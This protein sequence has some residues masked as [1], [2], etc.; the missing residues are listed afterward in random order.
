L[1]FNTQV[2]LSINGT[3]SAP[4]QQGRGLRQGDPLSPLLFNMMIDPLIRQIA[5]TTTIRGY[6]PWAK[7]Y[8]DLPH[9]MDPDTSIKIMAYADDM[10]VLLQDPK[11]WTALQNIYEIY[12]KASNA[13]LNVNKTEFISMSGHAWPQWKKMQ[14]SIDAGW[15]DRHAS[16]AARYLGYPI[17]SST[18]QLQS[19]W[20]G[21][22]AK[23]ELHC[24]VLSS[25]RLTI[26]GT[27]L[28]CNSIIFAKV[29]HVLRVTPIPKAWLT[30]LDQIARSFVLPFNPAPAWRTAKLPKNMG[31]L[32]IIDVGDQRAALQMNAIRRTLIGT[33][34]DILA[35]MN[36]GMLYVCHGS[37]DLWSNPVWTRKRKRK[38]HEGWAD[39][40]EL[41][42]SPL[43][44]THGWGFTKREGISLYPPVGKKVNIAKITPK[45]A[46][47]HMMDEIAGPMQRPRPPARIPGHIKTAKNAWKTI[48]SGPSHGRS[49]TI[50]WRWLHEKIPTRVRGLHRQKHYTD[51]TCLL[52]GI[53]AE[54]D[55]HF[56]VTCPKKWPIWQNHLP[57]IQ[58]SKILS[59]LWSPETIPPEQY[60]TICKAINSVWSAHWSQIFAPP[61]PTITRN[62]LTAPDLSDDTDY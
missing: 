41:L 45:I 26:R 24:R 22:T 46:R 11:E 31:G 8:A 58:Q 21:L 9:D 6:K 59:W 4:F 27:S 60:M 30:R 37:T 54:D 57:E 29:W 34:N 35:T 52:C 25:R 53:D 19:F 38:R 40:L 16:T 62:E 44:K 13:R 39:R 7:Y 36:R 15:H 28:L 55:Q 18:N 5:N 2:H 10:V 47:R 3:L 33:S 12:A 61:P 48:W 17:Y 1:F 49:L 42:R 20:E 23:L 14:R 51:P 50:W 56:M 43:A 32:G